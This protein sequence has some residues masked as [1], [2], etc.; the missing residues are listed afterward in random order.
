MSPAAARST[1]R[2]LGDVDARRLLVV[3]QAA[4]GQGALDHRD[5]LVL[6]ERLDQVGG[7]AGGAH[8]RHVPPRLARGQHD[9]RDVARLR[10]AL[11]RVDQLEAGH[12]R[13]LVVADHERRL[14]L[15]R[16]F[17]PDA[18][19]LG[20]G[21][22][23]ALAGQAVGD[24]VAQRRGIVHHQDA[25]ARRRDGAGQELLD[26]GHE[27]LR[28]DRLDQVVVRADVEAALQVMRLAQ[29]G[30][31]EHRHVAERRVP[32]D[33]GAHRVAVE[34]RHLDV[35][36]EEIR[37]LRP[38][39]RERLGAV[40]RAH[41][42]VAGVGQDRHGVAVDERRVVGQEDELARPRAGAEHVEHL[43]VGERR[44]Q[45]PVG[46]YRARHLAVARLQ[47]DDHRADGDVLEL[48]AQPGDHIRQL[49]VRQPAR[50]QDGARLHVGQRALELGG[51]GHH[52]QRVAE[53]DQRPAEELG[54]DRIGRDQHHL[55]E[56]RSLSWRRRRAT[57][58][59]RTWRSCGLVMY[60][61]TPASNPRT[62]SMRSPRLVTITIGTSRYSGVARSARVSS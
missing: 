51:A 53:R 35:E 39:D 47:P 1:A 25:L 8:L 27:L 32:L 4:L 11:E 22:L 50:Q 62:R 30:A 28:H 54:Q 21:D 2:P 40:H 58:L 34:L 59:S 7:G 23:E 41:H 9:D 15:Q 18:A 55:H 16:L 57:V 37:R 29:R 49:R 19:V 31:D 6:G 45:E 46:V 36:D 33:L 38:A 43:A 44:E 26:P 52:G 13:H 14:E 10:V 61:S 5:A 3:E 60:S 56:P 20:G 42:L 24:V 48:A 17:Q 12:L